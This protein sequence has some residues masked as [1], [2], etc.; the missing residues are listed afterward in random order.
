MQNRLLLLG[1]FLTCTACA[2]DQEDAKPKPAAS[3]EVP[4]AVEVHTTIQVK[5]SST[6]AATYLWNWGDGTTS[7]E[8]A[9]SHSYD[10]AGTFRLQLQ[11]TGAGGTD[12]ISHRLTVATDT[13][14]IVKRIIGKY[15][16]TL[17]FNSY[18]ANGYR[19]NQNWKRD[20]TLELVATSNKTLIL[21]K[22]TPYA[23]YKSDNAAWP[24][25]APQRKNY[26]FAYP[27]GTTSYTNIQVEQAGDSLYC[28][29][30][31]GGRSDADTYIFHGKKQR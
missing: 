23:D 5:N 9:P 21:L 15:R 31:N 24:G 25:S 20:T 8:Q 27:F 11:A 10:H 26:L 19:P 16:G 4:A 7:T 22:G 18:F 17:E 6:N 29:S 1:A 12:T 28:Y 2:S 13:A 3:F 30:R 14:A